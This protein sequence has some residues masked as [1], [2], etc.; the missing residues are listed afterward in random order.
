[1]I[2]TLTENTSQFTERLRQINSIENTIDKGNFIEFDFDDNPVSRRD[3]LKK[4]IDE[5]FPICGFV[6]KEVDLQKLYIDKYASSEVN[7]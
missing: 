5:G 6:E 3:L 4:L 2:L 7:K 1:M